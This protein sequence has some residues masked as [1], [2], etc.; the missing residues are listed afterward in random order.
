MST[1]LKSFQPCSEC[2]DTSPAGRHGYI[3]V[4]ADWG[5]QYLEECP[6]HVEWRKMNDLIIRM[7]SS[8]LRCDD[9]IL[10]YNIDKDYRG[11]KSIDAINKLKKFVE[12]PKKYLGNL[13]YLVG[14]N[15]T[16]KSTVA[17]WIGKML[18]A[19]HEPITTRFMLMQSLIRFLQPDFDDDKDIHDMEYKRLTE[20]TQ[21]LI[22]DEAFS[23]DKVTLYK[24]GYQ[25]PFLDQFLRERFDKN[26]LT[27]IFISNVLPEMIAENGFSASIQDF[28]IRNTRPI[29]TVLEFNDNYKEEAASFD[30]KGLFDE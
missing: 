17:N 27:T 26:R 23:K 5:G 2:F 6:C 1:I 9:Q 7:K 14:K 4:T 22:I 11:A 12:K 28:I 29:K 19:R 15:G 24:S 3:K 21:V 20:K 10:F 25:I 30:I 18:L 8:G 13:I 16:Q